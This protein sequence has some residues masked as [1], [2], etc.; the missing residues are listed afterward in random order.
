MAT[1]QSFEFYTARADQS[2]AEAS[3]ADLANVR[4]RALRSEKSWRGLAAQAKRV[5]AERTK[6]EI[7]RAERRA[8]EEDQAAALAAAGNPSLA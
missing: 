2:A 7:E 5:L 8:G 4:D 6:A 3:A 1:T